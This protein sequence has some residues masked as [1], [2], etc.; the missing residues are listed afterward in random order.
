MSIPVAGS[1]LLQLGHASA[2]HEIEILETVVVIIAHRTAQAVGLDSEASLAGDIGERSIV[3][4]VVKRWERFAGFVLRPIHGVHEEDVLPA[5]VVVVEK[6]DA[7]A[8]GFRKIFFA[9]GS[10][11][12]FE[13]DT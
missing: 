10:G 7:A 4:V 12:V 9:E 8:H 5:V 3:I 6:T 13:A 11:V 1:G 2:V